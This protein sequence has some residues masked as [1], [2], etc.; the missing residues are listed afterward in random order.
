MSNSRKGGMEKVFSR[1]L[2]KEKYYGSAGHVSSQHR[3]A[4]GQTAGEGRIRLMDAGDRSRSRT[5]PKEGKRSHKSN[6]IKH[7]AN[8]PT[9]T[10]GR[11]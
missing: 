11:L 4:A 6:L 8:R 9:K 5:Y 10:E 1:L 3:F 2:L 7:E